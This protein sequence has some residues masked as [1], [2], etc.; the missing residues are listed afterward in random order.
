MSN[1][2]M[3]SVQFR[4][5]RE[6]GWRELEALLKRIGARDLRSLNARDLMRLPVLYR[7]VLSSLSVARSVSLDK[8]LQAYLEALSARAYFR[9]YGVRAHAGEII[10]QFFAWRFASLA[11]AAWMAVL[12][13][14][15]ITLLGAIVSYGMTIENEDLYYSFVPDSLSHGRDPSSTAEELRLVLF[16]AEVKPL[17]NLQ[18]FATYLFTHNSLVG[19]FAFA[20]GFAFGVPT[21][22]LLFYNGLILGAFVALHVNRGLGLE[23]AGWLS[24]HGTTELT[25]IILCGAAGLMIG[26]AAAFPRERSRLSELSTQGRR[27]GLIVVGAIFMLLIA[28][29]LEG[30]GR[31]VVQDTDT[32]LMVGGGAF[33]FWLIYFVRPWRL[34]RRRA[35]RSGTP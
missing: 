25:A 31:Q 22:I 4:R 17:E 23:L 32:R 3:K 30:I 10:G 35:R 13:S 24:I 9:V 6:A 26:G 28:G 2:E 34:F 5:E 15:L 1:I 21:V 8:G 33:A 19:M 11:R 27:A 18:H 16:P 20:L 12:I 29:L 7:A 14:V